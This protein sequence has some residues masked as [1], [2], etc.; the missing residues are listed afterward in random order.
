MF[1]IIFEGNRDLRRI[2]MSPDYLGVP[3]RKDFYLADDASRAPGRHP[4]HG[5]ADG[6]RGVAATAGAAHEPGT[7]AV[8]GADGERIA[9]AAGDRGL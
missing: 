7:G 5:D 8:L 1:G 6:A 9:V 4:P 3:L 2:Y